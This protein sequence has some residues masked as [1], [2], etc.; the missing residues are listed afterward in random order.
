MSKQYIVMQTERVRVVYGIT[1]LDILSYIL[2][3]LKPIVTIHQGGGKM[4]D[5]FNFMKV[6]IRNVEDG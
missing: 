4:A 5:M 6:I 3:V 1:H 2:G